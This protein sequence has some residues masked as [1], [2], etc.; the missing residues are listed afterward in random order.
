MTPAQ[1]KQARKDAGLTQEEAASLVYISSSNWRKWE[2]EAPIGKSERNNFKART[3]LF[4][5][6]VKG[7]V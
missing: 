1:L 5:F 4:Q 7:E 3:E 6:K 2:S